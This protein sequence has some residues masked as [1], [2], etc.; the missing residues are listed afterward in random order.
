MVFN[1]S[2][3]LLNR[4]QKI[5]FLKITKEKILITKDESIKLQMKKEIKITKEKGSNLPKKINEDDYK[6]KADEVI[7]KK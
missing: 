2:F 3:D 5:K 7:G 4:L 1:K 6:R